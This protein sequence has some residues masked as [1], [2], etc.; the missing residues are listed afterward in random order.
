MVK[1]FTFFLPC[2]GEMHK[3]YKRVTSTL[4]Q[5]LDLQ[6]YHLLKNETNPKEAKVVQ[7][8]QRP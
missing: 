2:I 6:H 4:C 7:G 8:K 1:I 5:L 3:N